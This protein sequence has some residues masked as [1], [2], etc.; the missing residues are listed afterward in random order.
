MFS[1]KQSILKYGNRLLKR[2]DYQ[3][4]STSKLKS[5]T[6][7]TSNIIRNTGAK[8]DDEKI[9]SIVF[10]K[11]RAMQLHAFLLSYTEKVINRGRM[12]VLYKCSN[13]K[14]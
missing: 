8:L 9:D 10:S 6:D 2:F 13:N 7:F 11:D 1:Y 14:T 5:L 12:N 4:T 3:L